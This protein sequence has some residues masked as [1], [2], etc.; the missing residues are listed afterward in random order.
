MDKEHRFI[1]L[2]VLE[3]EESK[4]VVLISCQGILLHDILIEALI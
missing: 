4:S 1:W 2:V 3:A